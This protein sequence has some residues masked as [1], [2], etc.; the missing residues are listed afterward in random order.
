MYFPVTTIFIPEHVILSKKNILNME[1]QLNGKR[2]IKNPPGLFQY[3]ISYS[4][5]GVNIL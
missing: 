3:C 5:T 4:V 1:E 2:V